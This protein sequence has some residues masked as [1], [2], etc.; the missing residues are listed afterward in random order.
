MGESCLSPVHE[1]GE[2][3]FHS[4]EVAET[5]SRCEKAACLVQR[6][7]VQ[8]NKIIPLLSS[9]L[10]TG[11]RMSEMKACHSEKEK[12]EARTSPFPSLEIDHVALGIPEGHVNFLFLLSLLSLWIGF[13]LC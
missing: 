7:D 2:K 9:F 1:P 6:E 5:G 3:E 4:Q 13:L 10:P 11:R 12:E 8:A